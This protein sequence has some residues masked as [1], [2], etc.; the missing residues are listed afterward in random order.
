MRRPFERTIFIARAA[1]AID[2]AIAGRLAVADHSLWF[3]ICRMRRVR[4][5]S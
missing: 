3:T 5:S 2:S 4:A 1:G